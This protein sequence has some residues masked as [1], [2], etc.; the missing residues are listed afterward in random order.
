M[1]DC[2]FDDNEIC[3]GILEEFSD[4]RLEHLKELE[5]MCFSYLKHEMEFVKFI[6]ARS[7]KLKKVILYSI[8]VKDESDISTILS[9]A[10]R[11]SPEE[12]VVRCITF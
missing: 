12:I 1:D 11:A 6:L 3:C 7:P 9:Q 5:I 4:V 10:P 2:I 8:I